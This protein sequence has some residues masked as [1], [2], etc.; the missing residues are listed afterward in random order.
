[1]CKMPG[2]PFQQGPLC[3]ILRGTSSLPFS[4][5]LQSG[6]GPSSPVITRFCCYGGPP[7]TY[8]G[9]APRPLSQLLRPSFSS[10]SVVRALTDPLETSGG[11][12]W[13]TGGG[14][15]V[16]GSL[17]PTKFRGSLLVVETAQAAAEACDA[18]LE[19]CRRDIRISNSY[20]PVLPAQHS[21][22]TMNLSPR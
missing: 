14:P 5:E 19:A 16:G 7:Q 2:A 9:G 1:M 10:I 3:W 20:R 15:Q 4:C 12:R 6:R 8:S 18:I 17:P 13:I 11:P 22:G 21:R